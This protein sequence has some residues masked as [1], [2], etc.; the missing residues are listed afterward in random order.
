MEEITISVSLFI[1]LVGMSLFG[2]FMVGVALSVG[3]VNLW[4]RDQMFKELKRYNAV[5]S[6][7]PQMGGEIHVSADMPF[8]TDKQ[9]DAAV[10]VTR[11]FLEDRD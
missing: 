10:K 3:F 11:E 9:K 2:L 5:L 6:K 4:H 1:G 8:L 7:G